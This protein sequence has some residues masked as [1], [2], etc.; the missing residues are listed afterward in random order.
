[1]KW[2]NNL[3]GA[4]AHPSIVCD[5]LTAAAFDAVEITDEW[6]TSIRGIF[7]F[8][9]RH[10]LRT[11]VVFDDHYAAS[12]VA[13]P[14]DPVVILDPVNPA[15]NVASAWTEST[16]ADFLGRV[17]DAY[18]HMMDARSFELDDREEDAVDAWCQVFGE[19]FRV[20]SEPEE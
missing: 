3:Q 18:D 12:G 16:R 8:L 17:Q 11:P 2:W 14:R 9:R 4:A 15:N 1:M 10:A 19:T 13:V 7:N 5:L 6:Q 20:L